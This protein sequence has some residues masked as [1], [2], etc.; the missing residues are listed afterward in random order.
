MFLKSA[1]ALDPTVAQE[2]P[3][4]NSDIQPIQGPTRCFLIH[5]LALLKKVLVAFARL[6]MSRFNDFFLRRS[7]SPTGRQLHVVGSAITNHSRPEATIAC[8]SEQPS[9]ISSPIENCIR[10]LDN[11]PILI[12]NYE[13]PLRDSRRVH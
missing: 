11:Y 6:S 2:W 4:R 9:S 3:D 7:A 8:H 13:A 12:S 10:L 5:P 1:S